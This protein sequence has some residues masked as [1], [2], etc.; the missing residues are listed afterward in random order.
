[1]PPPERPTCTFRELLLFETNF[2]SSKV[3]FKDRLDPEDKFDKRLIDFCSAIDAWEGSRK[4]AEGWA[5]YDS[6][7]ALHDSDNAIMPVESP[8]LTTTNHVL[9]RPVTNKLV[10]YTTALGLLDIFMLQ[11]EIPGMRPGILRH[12]RRPGWINK[13]AAV[14]SIASL[15]TRLYTVMDQDVRFKETVQSASDTSPSSLDPVLAV[16]KQIRDTETQAD[17]MICVNNFAVIAFAVS[18]MLKGY[19]EVPENL[20]IKGAT[21]TGALEPETGALEYVLK[22]VLKYRRPLQTAVGYTV[23]VAFS[24][25]LLSDETV[26]TWHLLLN[27]KRRGSDKPEAIAKLELDTWCAIIRVAVGKKTAFQAFRSLICRWRSEKTIENLTAE[28]ST[29]FKGVSLHP[30][31]PPHLDHAFFTVLAEPPPANVSLPSPALAHIHMAVQVTC[32]QYNTI[33]RP[34]SAATIAVARPVVAA[35]KTAARPVATAVAATAA[36][37]ASASTVATGPGP[38]AKTAARPV[39]AAATTVATAVAATA[40]TGASASTLASTVATGPG[41]ASKTAARPVAAAAPATAATD[42]PASSTVPSKRLQIQVAVEPR[43]SPRLSAINPPQTQSAPSTARPRPRK[44][45]KPWDRKTLIDFTEFKKQ[46]PEVLLPIG[47]ELIGTETRENDRIDLDEPVS[48][49]PEHV[50][51]ITAWDDQAQPRELELRFSTRSDYDCWAAITAAEKESRVVDSDGKCKPLFAYG[52]GML[53]ER[54]SAFHLLSYDDPRDRATLESPRWT[55]FSLR[56]RS[57]VARGIPDVLLLEWD[58]QSMETVGDTEAVVEIHDLSIPVKDDHTPRL[59]TGTLKDVL[60]A[61]RKP[62]LDRRPLNAISLPKDKNYGLSLTPEATDMRALQRTRKLPGCSEA[63]PADELRFGLVATAGAHHPPHI[64]S[65]GLGTVVDIGIGQKLWA[66]IYPKDKRLSSS[67]TFWSHEKLDIRKIDFSQFYVEIMLLSAGNR[68]IMRSNTIHAVY[69]TENAICHGRHYLSTTTLQ[70]AIHGAVHSFFEGRIATNVDHPVFEQQMTSIAAYFYH[71]LVELDNPGTDQDGGYAPDPCTRAGFKDLIRFACGIQILGIISPSMYTVT[72]DPFLVEKL[73]KEDLSPR[74]GLEKYN[75]SQASYESRRQ[76]IF[77]RGRVIAT[78]KHVFAQVDV[79]LDFDILDPWR[80]L[81]IP[82]LAHLLYALQDYYD[83]SSR[84]SSTDNNTFPLP[85]K[86]LFDR[87]VESVAGQWPELLEDLDNLKKA[88]EPVDSMDFQFPG[89][90]FVSKAHMSTP[91][92][93][94]SPEQILE[95]GLCHVDLW[96]LFHLKRYL[97]PLFK[98]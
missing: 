19:I 78:L 40:A 3:C 17:I 30:P 71:H 43:K 63:F 26:N 93:P 22:N 27:A 2:P 80:D 13:P 8:L 9:P 76:L 72:D 66:I 96:Y 24:S 48:E 98:P 18:V 51:R 6:R 7:M 38:A 16:A 1:M 91:P 97:G 94:M 81:F 23:M 4:W 52:C 77:A 37:G 79:Q 58:L 15:K 86:K 55:Q 67:T 60:F 89:D 84:T 83:R 12:A 56:K 62:P 87:Q 92:V 50:L 73:G 5:S 11:K 42:N 69:T 36:T 57:I 25:K 33:A 31:F 34:G 68:L 39:V 95:S 53:G 45:T 90:F 41:P 54:E 21:E 59:R 82:S 70:D 35:T 64:D 20:V 32:D 85:T 61:G 88:K 29:F 74:E 49:L 10:A 44:K 28:E 65:R 75:I 46:D 47:R 14:H